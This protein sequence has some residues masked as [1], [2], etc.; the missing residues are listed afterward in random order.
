M[1]ERISPLAPMGHPVFRAIWFASLASNLGGLIQSVGAAWLM[2]SISASD[3]MVALVQ[4]ST[5]LPI[6]IFSLAAGAI[7]DNFDR[8]LVMLAAQLLMLTASILLAVCGSA[9]F[10]SLRS[11]SANVMNTDVLTKSDTK[12]GTAILYSSRRTCLLS[13]PR[14]CS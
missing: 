7:A 6:M 1:T 13:S 9:F 8:R 11:R 12:A 10:F 3:D 2:T 4:A 5:T 14:A